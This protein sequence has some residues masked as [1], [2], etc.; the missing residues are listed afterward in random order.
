MHGVCPCS[1]RRCSPSGCEAKQGGAAPAIVLGEGVHPKPWIP[2]GTEGE[3]D[4]VGEPTR[5]RLKVRHYEVDAY[6][7]VNHATY[8]HYLEVARLEALEA[9]GIPLDAM[10]RQGYLIVATHL[11]VRFHA[12]ARSGEILDVSTHIRELT[13]VRSVW[14]Q[15]IREVESRRLVVTADVTG[16]FTTEEG[17]PVRIP[18]AF[19]EKLAAL[20]SPGI[21]AIGGDPDSGL[22]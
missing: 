13:G 10:R 7:H 19:R 17:R 2:D 6:A 4:W 22:A 12:S 18:A 14:A 1:N 9:L 20:Y 21:P 8:V 3:D 15:E 16:V 5:F 11:S